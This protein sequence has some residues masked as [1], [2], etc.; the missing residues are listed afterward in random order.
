[1]ANI[2][3]ING[4]LGGSGANYDSLMGKASG[5]HN[6]GEI[7][8]KK[9]YFGG[10]GRI[11]YHVGLFSGLNTVITTAEQ[12]RTTKAAVFKAI[13]DK[14]DDVQADHGG[15]LNQDLDTEE[16]LN[17]I[18]EYLQRDGKNPYLKEAFNFLLGGENG[19]DPLSRDEMKMLDT[20]LKI[21]RGEHVALEEGVDASVKAL[22]NLKC[23]KLDRVDG[24]GEADIKSALDWVQGLKVSNSEDEE[25]LMLTQTV[26]GRYWKDD[27]FDHRR[28]VE[29]DRHIVNAIDNNIVAA[30]KLPEPY[31]TKGGK[32]VTPKVTEDQIN[33]LV[34][35]LI[36]GVGWQGHA[37]ND[38]LE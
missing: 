21:G 33:K 16:G 5:V 35:R 2:S 13:L 27:N 36:H 37:G 32:L 25:T 3:S 23:V 24:M 29:R 8:F 20:L 34:D 7:V 30:P 12:N 10:F 19:S 18:S 26:N 28:V 31:K 9:G 22:E 38:E 1:M 14:Y 6:R 17:A 15:I 4:I 11:N